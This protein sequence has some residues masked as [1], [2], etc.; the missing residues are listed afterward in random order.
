MVEPYEA[1]GRLSQAFDASRTHSRKHIFVVTV[2]DNPN[3]SHPTNSC[4]NFTPVIQTF[5]KTTISPKYSKT[6][7]LQYHYALNGIKG[8]PRHAGRI[9]STIVKLCVIQS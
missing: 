5:S 3:K 2:Y 9:S 1:C 6:N 4:L 8:Y 7:G